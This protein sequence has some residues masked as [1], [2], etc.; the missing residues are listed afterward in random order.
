M[1]P[2]RRAG[3]MFRE[4]WVETIRYDLIV[5]DAMLS[6][7]R[8]V[9]SET[10]KSGLPGE[11]HFYITYATDY[12]GVIIPEVLLKKYPHEITVVLQDEFENL[13]VETEGFHVTLWFDGEETDL[14]IPFYALKDFFDPSVKFGLQFNITVYPENKDGSTDP[15]TASD[16]DA[17]GEAAKV[18]SLDAFRKK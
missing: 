16:D 13:K 11:H 3:I 14:Y 18:I 9:L 5:Q 6:V 1:Q 4:F 7:V 15:Q 10:Q 12:P 8:R 2:L 17:S